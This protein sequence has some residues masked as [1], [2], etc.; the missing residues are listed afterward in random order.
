MPPI[1]TV[2]S[3]RWTS[4]PVPVASAMG[5]NLSAATNA[6]INTGLNR[7]NSLPIRVANTPMVYHESFLKELAL[8]THKLI[9]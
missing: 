4:A 1:T 8:I 9:Q 2:A 7:V 6:V 5:A 3:G